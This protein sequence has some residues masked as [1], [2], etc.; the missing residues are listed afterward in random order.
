MRYSFAA[1]S[2]QHRAGLAT[3]WIETMY[4]DAILDV[5]FEYELVLRANTVCSASQTYNC[6]LVVYVVPR[7]PKQAC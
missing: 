1:Y 5:K 4:I 7:D 2:A 3:Q 6:F